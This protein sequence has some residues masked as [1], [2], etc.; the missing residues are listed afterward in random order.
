MTEKV[1]WLFFYFFVQILVDLLAT[2]EHNWSISGIVGSKMSDQ[3]DSVWE[4]ED[5]VYPGFRCKYCKSVKRESV[6]PHDLSNI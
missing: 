3:A 5:N 1:R 2:L 6:V 4:H